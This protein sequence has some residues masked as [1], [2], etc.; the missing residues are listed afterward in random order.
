MIQQMLM[1]KLQDPQINVV[2]EYSEA[3]EKV[4]VT[5]RYNGEAWDLTKKGDQLS[6]SVLKSV[7]EEISWKW[8]N[9]INC[10]GINIR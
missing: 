4:I 3:E 10:V 8:E 5:I 2:I 6:L 7:A 9:D 1:Q